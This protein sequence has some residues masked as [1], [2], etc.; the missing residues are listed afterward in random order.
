MAKV[1]SMIG[2]GEQV[3]MSGAERRK[4]SGKKHIREMRIL[5]AK[6]KGLTIEHHFAS[7]PDQPYQE[8]ESHVFAKDQFHSHVIPHIAKTL[9]MPKVAPAAAGDEGTEPPEGAPAAAAAGGEEE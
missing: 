2:G 3:T 1:Q 7:G 8:P 4:A 6:N 9:G 5:P